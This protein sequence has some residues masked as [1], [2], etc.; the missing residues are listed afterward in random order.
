MLPLLEVSLVPIL[1]RVY[2]F[3]G[4]T[5]YQD[6]LCATKAIEITV[7]KCVDQIET[8]CSMTNERDMGTTKCHEEYQSCSS[9]SQVL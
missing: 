7:V 4:L 3:S 2:L 6:G 5:C 1:L 8:K 9:E